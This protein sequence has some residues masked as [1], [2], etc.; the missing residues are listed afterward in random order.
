MM[1]TD[2][3]AW[4][5]RP[6]P[7]I[8]RTVKWGGALFCGVIAVVW[9]GT[10]WWSVSWTGH[11]RL[12]F[13]FAAGGVSLGAITE[14]YVRSVAGFPSSSWFGWRTQS[15]KPHMFLW[16]AWQ[17]NPMAWYLQVPL[18][19]PLLM[20]LLP[21]AFA[22]RLDALARRRARVG[23]CPQC[24]YDRGGLA[25]GAVCPEC[26]APPP[27]APA[28]ATQPQLTPFCGARI[29][30]I[31]AASGSV[32]ALCATTRLQGCRDMHCVRT[33]CPECGGKTIARPLLRP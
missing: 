12:Y 19:A 3:Y 21:T 16:F 2:G 20:A 13:N 5:M 31:A 15:I 11:N 9:V 33:L 14:K 26:G 10:V 18:W 25:P 24:H 8:R 22:G 6:H 1:A 32:A 17:D 4:A 7:R 27:T 29:S 23:A 30:S 28:A